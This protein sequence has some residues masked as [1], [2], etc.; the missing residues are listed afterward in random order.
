[1]LE[2]LSDFRSK[3]DLALN[4]EHSALLILDM[5]RYF[6]EEA[7]HA[8]IPSGKAIIPGIIKLIEVYDRKALP[9][10]F[11]RHLNSDA[12]AGMM[13]KWWRDLIREDDPLRE[14]IPELD[15]TK[16]IV[17]KKSQY[18][19]FH[20]T[21][22]EDILRQKNVTQL[23]ICG[24]MT[25]LCCETT[26]RAAFVRGFEVFFTIDGTASYNEDF[27]R[28]ALLNLSYG[29]AVPV[30]TDEILIALGAQNAH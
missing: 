19:A 7:S 13:S 10:V 12:D 28:A 17:I 29:F 25:H 2:E 24:V 23:V 30:L 5:Q 22:L 16:G 11:T 20:H 8:F 9:I 14:I 6:F 18:D 27:H 21:D 1:M 26:A 4:P 3:H 15:V